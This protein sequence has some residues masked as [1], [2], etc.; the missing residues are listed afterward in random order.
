MSN[1]M[2]RLTLHGQ[3]PSP[4]GGE[5]ETLLLT[6]DYGTGAWNEKSARADFMRRTKIDRACNTVWIVRMQR[7]ERPV[8]VEKGQ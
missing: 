1:E 3:R 5:V 6:C 8:C 2:I 7:M 4:D